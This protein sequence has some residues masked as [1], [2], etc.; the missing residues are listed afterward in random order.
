MDPSSMLGPI[1]WLA[2][3]IEYIVF[4]LIIANMGTRHLQHQHHKQTAEAGGES[5]SRHPAHVATNVALIIGTFYFL[6]IEY[7]GGIVLS[8][9]VL[10]L[11]IADFF[12]FE[13]RELELRN[14]EDLEVPKAAIAASGLVFLYA[15][16]V[17]VF[18]IIEPAW[19]LVF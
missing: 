16:Y 7:H 10:G 3:F 15:F 14:G 9:L 12:E 4:L 18:F 13:S 1:D 17:S 11:I 5:L 2:P 19:R 8:V 6:S